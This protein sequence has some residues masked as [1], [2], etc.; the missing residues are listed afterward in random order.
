MAGLISQAVTDTNKVATYKPETAQAVTP[1]STGY[2]A[3]GV[4]VT[5]QET[6]QGQ[7]ADITSKDSPLMQQAA[8][9]ANE[10]MTSR[11]LLNSSIAVGAGQDAVLNSALPIA[12]QD[13][14]TYNT[15]N[16]KTVDANNAALNFGANASNQASLAGAQLG[17]DVSKTNAQFG[18]AAQEQAATAANQASLANLDVSSKQQLSAA[19]IASRE[20]LGLLNSATQKELASLDSATRL[21]L[22][23]MDAQ[24]RY[25]ISTIENQYRQLLQANT[26]AASTYSQA[27]NAIGNISANPNLTPQAKDN[28]IATQMNMLR[29]AMATTEAITRTTPSTVSSLDLS[30][31]FTTDATTK[32]TPE[33]ISKGRQPYQAAVDNAKNA[34]PVWPENYALYQAPP[35]P[36]QSERTAANFNALYAQRYQEWQNAVAAMN[37]YD[38]QYA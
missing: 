2:T 27:V 29:E 6:V 35:G 28:A 13:A 33:Q 22:Q 17:T 11:G 30:K 37:S 32:L 4:S 20:K 8:R 3:Q 24:S 21:Q 7:L 31:F 19:D 10:Q 18:N 5:P 25:Q 9:R 38:A 14:S 15:A 34:I 16:L 26:N 12:Q 1:T 36:N 23:N